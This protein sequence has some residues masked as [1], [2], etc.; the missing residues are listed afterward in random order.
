MTVGLRPGHFNDTGSA[1]LDLDIEMV[2]HLGVET[3]VYARHGKGELITVATHDGRDAQGRRQAR[4][5]FRSCLGT[6]V[7]LRRRPHPV[8]F[9]QTRRPC[10]FENEPALL[11][12]LPAP[13]FLLP[14]RLHATGTSQMSRAYSRI[15][16]SAENQAMLATL[17]IALARQDGVSRHMASTSRCAAQ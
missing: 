12:S 9:G 3:F 5:A 7:R 13:V 1:Q 15:V 14:C 16:R 4:G 17:R 8:E 10:P 6:A 11:S 2:E